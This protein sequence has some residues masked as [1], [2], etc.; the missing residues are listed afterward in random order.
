MC[1]TAARADPF[2]G[3]SL[4]ISAGVVR[5]E[6][7]GTAA[8]LGI[9]VRVRFLGVWLEPEAGYWSRH[10]T[11]FGLQSSVRDV[12]A[13]ANAQ[14][15]LLRHGPA[16][17]LAAAGASAHGVTSSG[18]PLGGASAAETHVYPGLQGSLSF[19]LR[20]GKRSAAF[21]GGRGDWIL[22]GSREDEQ[23]MRLFGGIRLGF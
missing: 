17:L 16:R 12:H 18:G 21:V 23:E 8:W 20:L 10:E 15:A 14:W 11:A 13:G 6:A 5:P 7:V 3:R 9:G 4:R 1:G 22:R 19:E 2:G